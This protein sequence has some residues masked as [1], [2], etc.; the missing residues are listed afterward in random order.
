MKKTISLLLLLSICLVSAFALVSCGEE[1]PAPS[2][3]D[4]PTPPAD[5]KVSYTVTVKDSDGN[6]VAGVKLM[7]SDGSSLFLNAETGADGKA[8]VKSDNE[9]ASLGVMITSVP[10]GYEKPT[11]TSGVFHAMFGNQKEVT[12]TI[13]KPSVETIT[14]TVRI[15]DQNGNAVEGVEVQICHSVCVQCPLTDAD[16]VTTKE[17]PASVAEGTLKVGIL[18]VPDGYTKP[19]ATV[20]GGYH[21][22]IAPDEQ[23]VTITI[24]KN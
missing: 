17:L 2:E 6:A 14:Y 9:N 20:E 15:V 22:T 7:V 19:E 18:D 4:N 24:T 5:N 23:T 8:T 10:S 11:A 13:S 21:A 12:V 16:G 3:G 1:P